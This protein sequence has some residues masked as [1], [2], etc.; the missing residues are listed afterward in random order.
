MNIRMFPNRSN[1]VQS[2]HPSSASFAASPVRLQKVA[3]RK[4]KSTPGLPATSNALS[5]SDRDLLL[6]RQ[7]LAYAQRGDY[8]T[9]IDLFDVLIDHTPTN[10][11]YYNNR[12]LIHFQNGDIEAALDDYDCALQ[13]NPSLAK[14]YNNRANC[15]IALGDLESAIADYDTAIDLNPT[16]LH[17]LINQGITYRELGLYELAIE[18]FEFALHLC[19]LLNS[20]DL[21]K[22]NLEGHLYAERGRTRHLT[23]DWNCAI[24]DYRRALTK[25]PIV[26]PPLAYPSDRLRQ[27]VESWLD[28]LISPLSA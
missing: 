28:S 13:L 4:P 24:A 22:P 23:G 15:Y 19:N 11:S 2:S 25:L 26:D 12:G 1:S 20:A 21:S 18:N 6:R 10:A 17:A 5:P 3:A 9:A 16:N 8:N 14:V 27:Q 7:A